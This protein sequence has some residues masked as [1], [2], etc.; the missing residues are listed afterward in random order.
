MTFIKFSA[1]YTV[2]PSFQQLE[3]DN[4]LSEYNSSRLIH[5]SLRLLKTKIVIGCGL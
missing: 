1:S 4:A 2:V 3:R 5:L